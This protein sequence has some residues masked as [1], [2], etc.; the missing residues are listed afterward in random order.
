MGLLH[1]W[2]S[3]DR[4]VL[5]LEDD[6]CEVGELRGGRNHLQQQEEDCLAVLQQRE[7]RP[8]GCHH[9]TPRC[10]SFLSKLWPF[11]FI[12]F[13]SGIISHIC[14]ALQDI[15]KLEGELN[16]SPERWQTTLERVRISIQEDLKQE[17]NVGVI[18][19]STT[20]WHKT[21]V[22]CD[23]LV[24]LYVCC[25]SV[26]S[27]CPS[28]ASFPRPACRPSSGAPCCT[29]QTA[30]WARTTALPQPTG[31]TV[32]PQHST[33]SSPPR[34]RKT[35]G[36]WTS[37]V[38]EQIKKSTFDSL[39]TAVEGPVQCSFG[40]WLSAAVCCVSCLWGLSVLC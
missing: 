6:G 36:S 19:I 8:A 33:T 26:S 10:K 23:T 39:T 24:I 27:R 31:S 3:V 37:W 5:R 18:Q 40:R 30:G 21:V 38:P 16:Q 29:C 11:V 28:Q 13:S 4:S 35:G 20:K 25:S 9:Q 12:L 15:E 14:L 2:D 32:A 22:L 17:G 7:P 1:G 34:A